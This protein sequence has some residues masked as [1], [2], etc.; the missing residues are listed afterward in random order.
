MK[1]FALML[2]SFGVS[3]ES[4]KRKLSMCELNSIEFNKL[5]AVEWALNFHCNSRRILASYAQK[6]REVIAAHL[7]KMAEMG[8]SKEG[9]APWSKLIGGDGDKLKHERNMNIYGFDFW[10]EE[11]N[12]MQKVV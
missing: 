5:L 4:L 12:R 7:D 3:I 6:R 11:K 1:T 8:I 10:N 9:I 2:F